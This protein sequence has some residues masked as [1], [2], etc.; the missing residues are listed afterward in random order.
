[1]KG[2]FF[3]FCFRKNNKKRCDPTGWLDKVENEHL[4]WETG[5][6][7]KKKTPQVGFYP[8]FSL[9][10]LIVNRR[11]DVIDRSMRHPRPVQDGQPLLRRLGLGDVLRAA[12]DAGRAGRW[13]GSVCP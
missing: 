8:C 5:Q 9:T 12:R 11:L 4:D 7:L 10:M 3:R 6:K 13:S 2:I 1:M